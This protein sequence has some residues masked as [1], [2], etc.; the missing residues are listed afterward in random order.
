VD[1]RSKAAP[2]SDQ[3]PTWTAAAVAAA[4]RAGTVTAADAARFALER[5]ATRDGELAAFQV[6]RRDA[7]AREA[8]AVDARVAAGEQLPLAGVP[9]A[10]KDNIPVAGEP[11][12]NGS[13][14]TAATPQPRDHEVV[15]RLRAAGAVVVG[16][17]RVPELCVWGSTDSVYGVTRNPWAH[18][19]TPGGSSGGSAAAVAAGIVPIAHGADGMG[20]IRIPAAATGLVGIKPGMGVVPCDLGTTDWF[21]LS[22][23]GVFATTVADAAL[24]L[25]VI[26]ADPALARVGDAADGPT[27]RI[28]VST[29][30][31][32]QGLGVDREHVKALFASAASLLHAGHEVERSEPSYPNAAAIAGLSRWFAG[33]AADAEHLD[34]DLLEPRTRRH[35]AIGRAILDRGML[36]DG[37]RDQWREQAL[38]LLSTYDVLMSPVIA[39]PPPAAKRWSEASWQAN[40]L[41]NVPFAP[42][43]A[44]WNVAGFPAMSV[45]AGVHPKH[46]TPMSVQLVARPGR[47]SMLLSV[48]AALESLRPWPRT[49]P[50]Y[51]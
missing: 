27:L 15:T 44:A 43:A 3:L 5:I 20:S 51:S 40:M 22:E 18:G 2:S 46:G 32:L 41:A 33:T 38:S 13:A 36:D 24:M 50:A 49:A 10:I 45:P 37:P 16:I 26:A 9:V 1:T 23:N 39:T 34:P 21:G 8:D 7:A 6:V 4:V 30:P 11:M 47:E 48:A 31:P 12:R 28:A 19:R 29:K 42:F 25:S 14:A 17:T 35:A